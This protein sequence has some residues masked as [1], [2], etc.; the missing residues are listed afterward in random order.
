[1]AVPTFHV[2]PRG[3]AAAESLAGR[4]GRRRA[5]DR[6]RPHLDYPSASTLQPNELRS[7]WRAAPPVLEF[8]QDGTLLVV[9]RPRPRLRMAAA[10]ARHL[11]DAR[12]TCGSAAAAKRHA[13]PEVHTQRPVPACRS[14]IRARAAAATTPRISAAPQACSST[15]KPTNCTSRTVTL[16]TASSCSTRHRRLQAP[17]GRV[18]QAAGRRIFRAEAAN[19][20]RR[21]SAGSCSTRIGQPVQSRRSSGAAIPHRARSADLERWARLCVRSHE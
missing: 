12:T 16:T 3:Q 11:V 15:R 10:G 17:L 21:P 13:D 18:R 6:Q 7:V 9:G 1:M 20:C 14:A 8:D 5:V 2:D 19:I 4:R